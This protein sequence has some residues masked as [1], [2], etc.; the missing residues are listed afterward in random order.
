MLTIKNV[1]INLK[2]TVTCGQCFRF[3]PCEDESYTMILSDRVIN[4]KQSG[5]NL[6]V[7]SNNE[8]NLENVIREYFDLN[9][10]YVL[11]NKELLSFDLTLKDC[12][13]GSK[14]LKILKQE[15]FEMLISYIIS[16]N[17]KVTRISNSINFI[18]QKYGKK[19]EF[20][21]NIYY[22]FPSFEQIKNI[23]MDTLK[24]AKVGFRVKYIIEALNYIKEGNLDIQKIKDL[25]TDEALAYLERV[26]GIGPK[27]ASCILLFGYSRFDVFPID[28]W[29]KKAMCDL[30]KDIK[31]NQKE[32]GKFAKEKYGKNCGLALQYMYHYMRNKK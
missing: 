1:D 3:F 18:S 2:D 22:L 19:V 10:D 13:E 23:D 25:D 20:K 17:N 12:I 8:N 29:V 30:Y 9:R 32:I 27:V 5:R 14:G 24:E 28:T 21:N 11:L 7:E 26:K 31:P 16:Q 6:I 15:P 4:I